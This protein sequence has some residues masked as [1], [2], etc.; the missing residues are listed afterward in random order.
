MQW[1]M[2]INTP[3]REVNVNPYILN[4]KNG[5]YNVLTDE[6]SD[7]TPTILS[8]IRLGGNYNIEAE[9]P[10]FMKYLHDVLPET[11]HG[12]VQEMMGYLL[13]GINKAKKSFMFLGETDTGKS[14]ML[15][16]IESVLLTPDNVSTLPWQKL[17][18]RFNTIQLF[19]K[20]ANI[21]GDLSSDALKDTAAFK[22]ITGGDR[23]MGEYKHKDGFSF[24]PTV[25]LAYSLN[26]MP[27][28]YND[29]S[30]AFYK[31][32]I[33]FRF[34]N[35][36]PDDK[37][38]SDLEEKLMLEA[39][40]IT[41][42]A[43]VGLKRLMANKYKFGLTENTSRELQAYKMD[44]SVVLTF[45]HDCCQIDAK[46]AVVRVDLY[47]A[48]KEYLADNGLPTVSIN[49]FNRELDSYP[50][51]SRSQDSTAGNRK[52]WRGIRLR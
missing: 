14:T 28:S 49:S 1:R 34:A 16:V 23:I 11:E 6:F 13:I 29:R 44:N 31:R 4:F 8:T 46:A 33:L 27:K 47:N 12:L 43:L 22:A 41:A 32:L 52:I 20:L 48:F 24:R 35:H 2:E 17:D 18:E 38:D 45:V 19:G 50:G 26:A 15:H 5:L 36:I 40:G 7:H 25:R 37:Q 39:D 42:W 10:L 51:L 30:E 3:A 9:C 21:Y